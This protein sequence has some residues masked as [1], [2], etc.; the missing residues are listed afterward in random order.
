MNK[1]K[2]WLASKSTYLPSP[3]HF[4]FSPVSLKR[5]NGAIVAQHTRTRPRLIILLTCLLRLLRHI[6]FCFPLNFIVFL[7]YDNDVFCLSFLPFSP[8]LRALLPKAFGI[9]FFEVVFSSHPAIL[10]FAHVVSYAQASKSKWN[11]TLGLFS[12][13]TV[14]HTSERAKYTAE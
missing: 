1:C 4:P 3:L 6:S 8:F 5:A 11:L 2:S 9:T 14:E 10:F 13:V 7:S 12:H